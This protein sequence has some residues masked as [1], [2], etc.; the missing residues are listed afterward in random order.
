MIRRNRFEIVGQSLVFAAGVIIAVVFVSIMIIEFE[1]SR[2]LSDAVNENMIEMTAAVRDSGVL[3]YDGIRV[4]GADVLNFGKK[5]FYSSEGEFVL[6]ITSDSGRTVSVADKH[7]MEEIVAQSGAEGSRSPVDPSG[8]YL[9][10]V[11]KN[12]N[13]II[14]LVSFTQVQ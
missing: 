2:R 14:T 13:G 6:Q 5:Y 9:G 4:L 10:K 7:D 8:E 1:N 11:I 3:M 12:D